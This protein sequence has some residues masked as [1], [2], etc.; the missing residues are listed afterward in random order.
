M[1]TIIKYPGKYDLDDD[2]FN[3]FDIRASNVILNGHGHTLYGWIHIGNEYHRVQNVKINNLTI[4]PSTNICSISDEFCPICNAKI[5]DI[6]NV[7]IQK[8]EA[9]IYIH[10]HNMEIN[11]CPLIPNK[12]LYSHITISHSIGSII[13]GLIIPELKSKDI[14][15]FKDEV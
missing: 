8:N 15:Y 9:L 11:S 12:E 7:T 6:N 14:C 2:S 13:N 3:N 10:G 4:K 1:T 5:F